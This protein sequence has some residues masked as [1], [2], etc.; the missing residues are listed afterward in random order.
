ME[1]WY[2]RKDKKE[3]YFALEKT[4]PAKN[5]H[6]RKPDSKI[7]LRLNHE[8]EALE[9]LLKAETFLNVLNHFHKLITQK[10]DAPLIDPKILFFY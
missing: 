3:A 1:G 7:V 10:E 2:R 9:K 5:S 6:R 8:N 4:L